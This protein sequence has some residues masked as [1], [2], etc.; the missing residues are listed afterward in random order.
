MMED[1]QF[2]GPQF[3]YLVMHSFKYGGYR[4]HT[5]VEMLIGVIFAFFVIFLEID[6]LS[7]LI[8]TVDMRKGILPG[9]AKL[10]TTSYD[11]WGLMPPYPLNYIQ[12]IATNHIKSFKK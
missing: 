8:A 4:P 9:T 7:I 11:K 5:P 1:F 3:I 10:E 2:S 12:V 6:T